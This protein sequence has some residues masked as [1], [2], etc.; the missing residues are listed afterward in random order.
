MIAWLRASRARLVVTVLVVVA[1]VAGGVSLLAARSA[2]PAV[3]EEALR[4]P[5][6]PEPDGTPVD[7][8]V[9]VYTADTGVT[10]PK[11]AVMLA[12]GFGGQRQ[13]LVTQ[14]QRLAA[15]GY[16]VLT[17]TARGF[18][19]SGGRIHLNAP[20]YEVADAEALV[21]LLA[22]RDDVLLDAEGDPRVGVAGGSYGGA[23]ALLAA[24]YDARIDAIAPRITWH[25]LAQSLFPQFASDGEP[26]HSRCVRADRRP[27]R[28]QAAVGRRVLRQR[29]G[30]G[31]RADRVR[32]VRRRR[33]RR[34]QRQ[35]RDAVSRPRRSCACWRP[36]ARPRCSTASTPP[37]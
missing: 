17:W 18:G 29:L 9:G 24:G 16:V 25:D 12:H 6:G 14:A 4:V 21:D 26:T 31:D 37:R 3:A 1:L 34:L 13:D 15:Q 36:R 20:A 27:R 23:I 33:L 2:G 19:Q 28:L 11:P 30:L 35:R 10:S 32:P 5:V 22:A 8:D 7:L